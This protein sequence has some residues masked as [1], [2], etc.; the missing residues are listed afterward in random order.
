MK[1][2]KCFK[3]QYYENGKRFEKEFKYARCGLDIAKE[4]AENAR[5]GYS[6]N[7]KAEMIH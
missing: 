7:K 2:K 5:L 1:K 4:K 3:F 6:H